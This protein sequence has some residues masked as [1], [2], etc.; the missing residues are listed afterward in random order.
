[1]DAG[2]G[3]QQRAY[4]A[5]LRSGRLHAGSVADTSFVDSDTVDGAG[6]QCDS[7]PN[8]AARLAPSG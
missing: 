6:S 2:A 4:C 7:L 5:L 3:I 8:D 1:M